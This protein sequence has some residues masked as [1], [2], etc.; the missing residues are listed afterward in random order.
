MYD[1][2]A[3]KQKQSQQ[4]LD[5]YN[6]QLPEILP[7]ECIQEEVSES[8]TNHFFTA[9]VNLARAQGLQQRAAGGQVVDANSFTI[10]DSSRTRQTYKQNQVLDS[11]LLLPRSQESAA[12]MPP[13]Q[14]GDDQAKR[15]S[16]ALQYVSNVNNSF[17]N[18]GIN[19][20]P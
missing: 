15:K 4:K 8:N 13:V 2:L 6:S 16:G 12:S 18:N 9:N 20:Q 19:F 11:K 5:P 14:Y 3:E 7:L 17:N 10:L 1:I